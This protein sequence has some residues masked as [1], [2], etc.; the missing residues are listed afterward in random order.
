MRYDKPLITGLLGSVSTIPYEIFT[1]V[2]VMFGIGKYSAYQLTSL[3][4]TLNR[5][6]AILGMVMGALIGGLVAV[7]FY[8]SLKKMGPDYIILKSLFI[9]LLAWVFLE[10]VYVW[11]IEGPGLVKPRPIFDYYIHLSG[12][13]LYG[14]TLGIL[15]KTFLIK[16]TIHN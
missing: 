1:R 4:I 3:V 11:L 8:Y 14:L 10:V 15:L 13:F 5:P 6:R 7:I 12:S 2:F 16:E 9:G